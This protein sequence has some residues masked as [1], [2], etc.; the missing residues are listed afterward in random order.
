MKVCNSESQATL[1]WEERRPAWGHAGALVRWNG[2]FHRVA[3]PFRHPADGVASLANPVGSP[4][5][6]ALVGLLRLKALLKSPE[7]VLKAPETSTLE[8]LQVWT[9]RLAR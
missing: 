8:R 7:E 4:L 1:I 3:D 2:S 5:D 6:K 9:P